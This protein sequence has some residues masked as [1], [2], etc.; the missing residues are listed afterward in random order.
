MDNM[1]KV[2]THVTMVTYIFWNLPNYLEITEQ[3]T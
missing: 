2:Y 1:L 3:L